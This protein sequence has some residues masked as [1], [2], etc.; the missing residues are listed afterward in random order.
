[1]V[2]LRIIVPIIAEKK[3]LNILD[4]KYGDITINGFIRS[5]M[6]EV[7][8]EFIK[9]GLNE[10]NAFGISMEIIGVRITK[11]KALVITAVIF[12]FILCGCPLSA[13]SYTFSQP[14]FVSPE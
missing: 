7:S 13:Y 14:R 9:A 2:S 12:L 5:G 3:A 6:A 10:R 4:R 8:E 1:L 11:S